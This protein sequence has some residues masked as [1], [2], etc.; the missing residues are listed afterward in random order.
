MS[1]ASPYP[2]AVPP[3]LRVHRAG[4]NAIR[5]RCGHC[6]YCPLYVGDCDAEPCPDQAPV[7]NC[8]CVAC[9]E[10]RMP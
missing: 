3:Q 2:V 6:T 7:G 4:V 5:Q 9:T 1:A 8:P 10:E